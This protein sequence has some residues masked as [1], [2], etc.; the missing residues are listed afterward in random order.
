VI[1]NAPP[2][3]MIGANLMSMARDLSGTNAMY[4]E[5]RY[6]RITGAARLRL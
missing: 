6:L 2:A 1:A 5:T 3:T 4:A